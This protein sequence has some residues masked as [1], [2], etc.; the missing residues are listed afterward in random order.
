[1]ERPGKSLVEEARTAIAPAVRAGATGGDAA[2]R[3]DRVRAARSRFLPYVVVGAATFCAILGTVVAETA[4]NHRA[5][6]LGIATTAGIIAGMT[7][8]WVLLGLYARRAERQVLGRRRVDLAIVLVTVPAYAVAGWVAALVGWMASLN[9]SRP[10][11]EPGAPNAWGI[12]IAVAIAIYPLSYFLAKRDLDRPTD[13]RSAVIAATS[14]V[15]QTPASY[16]IA[17]AFIV[18][19]VWFIGA[20]FAVFAIL[21]AVQAVL[22]DFKL[23]NATGTLVGIAFLVAWFGLGV[24]GTVWTLRLIGRSGRR[25]R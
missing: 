25:R 14:E 11:P 7:V 24:A 12:L 1:L 3:A 9:L 15:N 5:T 19:M 23:E 22:P 21:I 20:L 16:R 10:M 18:G 2:T 13:F 4:E 8:G 6:V 17:L